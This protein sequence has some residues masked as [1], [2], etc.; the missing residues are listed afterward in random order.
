M[1]LHYLRLQ[2]GHCLNIDDK[3]HMLQKG[4]WHLLSNLYHV[5]HFN[6]NT[7]SMIFVRLIANFQNYNTLLSNIFL[8]KIF[9]GIG[10]SKT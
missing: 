8:I 10:R 4:K 5:Q 3:E 1:E 9:S 6:S 7:S 2:C